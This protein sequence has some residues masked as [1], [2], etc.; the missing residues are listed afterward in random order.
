MNTN[1]QSEL[2]VIERFVGPTPDF[3]KYIQVIGGMLAAIGGILTQLQDA[4]LTLPG[5]VTVGVGL[6]ASIVAQFAVD[7]KKFQEQGAL[8]GLIWPRA[9]V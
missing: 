6:A 8:N 1:L 7:L 5:W 3:F 9:T 4:G 2:T